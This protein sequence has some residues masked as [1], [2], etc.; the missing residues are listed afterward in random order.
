MQ[1]AFDAREDERQTL[2]DGSVRHAQVWVFDARVT[3]GQAK[4]DCKPRPAMFYVYVKDTDAVY[5]AC[6]VA[7]VTS[8]SEPQ[9][10]FYGDRNAGV[11][12]LNGNQWWIATHR[13]D[14]SSEEIAQRAAHERK[15]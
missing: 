10:H 15:G 14:L 6:L 2:P 12:D 1:K 3:I 9:N 8:V 4:G 5:K 13:E 11:R 7:G